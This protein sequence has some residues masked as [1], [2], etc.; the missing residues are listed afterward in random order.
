MDDVCDEVFDIVDE[1]DRVIGQRSRAETHRLG[2]LH[3]AVHV[4]VFD[5]A[6]RV[7]LQKRS[8]SKD[9]NPG[10]WD[11]SVGGH[12][13]SGED[14]DG[15]ALRETAEELGIALRQ[16]PPLLFKLDACEQTGWEFVQVYRLR[17][18]GPFRPQS[19]EIDELRWF[20]PAE[21]RDPGQRKDF[22]GALCLIWDTLASR[23]AC[24]PRAMPGPPD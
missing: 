1:R 21:M 14:Y 12:L 16:P 17:H 5:D 22:T 6:A 13:D 18:E 7:L 9:S 11:T 15:A 4:L 8:L 2:L 24:A 19:S 23:A 3:R 20:T 10:L